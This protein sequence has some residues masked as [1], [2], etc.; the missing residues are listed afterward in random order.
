[1]FEAHDIVP[2]PPLFAV[3]QIIEVA[4]FDGI[5]GGGA[6]HFL[7]DDKDAKVPSFEQ[8]QRQQQR[9]GLSHDTRKSRARMR[10]DC[11]KCKHHR[12]LLRLARSYNGYQFKYKRLLHTCA[13][14]MYF[15]F[16]RL[17]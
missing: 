9:S 1:M 2:R 10:P 5:M 17:I 15:Q 12:P 13:C 3:F 8:R 7:L 16:D 11:F 6:S 14:Q 4:A